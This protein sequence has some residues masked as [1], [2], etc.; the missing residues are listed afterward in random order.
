[1]LLPPRAYPKILLKT[2]TKLLVV[3]AIRWSIL[4]S[5]CYRHIDKV[6]LGGTL[7]FNEDDG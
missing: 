2:Q 5:L 7:L 6:R 1:M 3:N 4:F